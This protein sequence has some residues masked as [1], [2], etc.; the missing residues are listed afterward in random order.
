MPYDSDVP[1]VKKSL[2][3]RLRYF[4]LIFRRLPGL[5]ANRPGVLNERV[6]AV[7]ATLYFQMG[8]H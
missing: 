3:N 2:L 1:G 4:W 5:L 7:R 6:K 8:F